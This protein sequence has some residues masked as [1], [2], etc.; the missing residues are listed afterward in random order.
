MGYREPMSTPDSPT[1]AA[2][3]PLP[4]LLDA[5]SVLPPGE[6][7]TAPDRSI[8]QVTADSRDVATGALFV[9]IPG[10]NHDGHQYLEAAVRSGAVAALGTMTRPELASAGIHLPL[11]FP[12]YTVTN[13]RRALAEASAALYGF[14][15]RDLIV[16]GVTGTD[17]KTTTCALL[18]SILTAA[19]QSADNP[20]GRVGV[21]TTVGAH[22]RGQEQ[23][24]GFHVTTPESPDI[25]RYLAQ[26]RNSGCRYAIV[27][28]TS[29]GLAQERVAAVAY[30]VAAVTNI[31]HEH[32]DYHGT[33]EAYV[34]AKAL[35]FRALYEV[36]VG[37]GRDRFAV[38]NAD[39]EGSIHALR[40]VL[41]EEDA[42]HGRFMSRHL[43]GLSEA[44]TRAGSLQPDITAANVEFSPAQTSFTLRW[45]GGQFEVSTE[46]IGEFN[47]QNILCAAAIALGLNI[48]PQDVQRGVANMHG[49]SGRME[50]IDRGQ[51]FLAVVDFAHSPVSL[52]R[53]LQTLRPLVDPTPKEGSG[54]LIS[55]FGCAG[56][57]DKQKRSLMGRISG[58]LADF[59]VITAEDPR[60]EDLDVI[61]REIETG[62]L[63]Y[64]DSGAYRIIP[65]RTE[66]INFA[67][68][69]ARPGDV[70]AA[71]G[72]GHE[73][74]MCYGTTEY[75]WSDQKAM[76]DALEGLVI[77][78]SVTQ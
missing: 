61:N 57:R 26:M 67:V 4:R 25:Q 58:R 35:L 2:S 64:A 17:G 55:V 71:F 74:S 16:I 14:P 7:P 42:A 10:A 1:I 78:G 37:R 29:H 20:Q 32:L 28:S 27:E 54:R 47:V 48:S 72:K 70:V 9:A 53:A 39:D 69:M 19:T 77:S 75:P 5:L 63:E 24:T 30:D 49:V 62:V 36:P 38:L 46:L 6:G 73:R 50:R 15:S 40:S 8:V 59:T 13:A 66:A 23:E 12:Y 45:W 33:R 65:D 44:K 52:E 51:P 76:V 22:I 60:T 3:V 68:R 56:L 31:T 11:D 21:I 18:E 34:Q 43:Y 41:M